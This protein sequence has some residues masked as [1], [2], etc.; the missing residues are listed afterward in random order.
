MT[1]SL[2]RIV[3]NLLTEYPELCYTGSMDP[4]KLEEAGKKLEMAGKMQRVGCI[5]TLFVTI[6]IC[7][8]MLVFYLL[9]S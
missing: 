9:S 6:P 4:E 8:V 1:G 5:L 2:C 3:S 7:I